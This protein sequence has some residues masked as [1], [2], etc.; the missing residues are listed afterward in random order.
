MRKRILTSV[1]LVVFASPA[2]AYAQN[3]S[4]VGTWD[5]KGALFQPYPYGDGPSVL[6]FDNDG[7]GYFI[8]DGYRYSFSWRS[9]GTNTIGV[10]VA[11]L[12]TLGIGPSGIAREV[13][14]AEIIGNEFG[15]NYRNSQTLWL[16]P[17]MVATPLSRG[18]SWV[19]VRR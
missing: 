9:A 17:G 2:V 10:P 15:S 4:F 6:V 11:R 14:R 8:K 1:A 7:S 3:D 13:Y 18:Q 19:F 16:R 5:S 12:D